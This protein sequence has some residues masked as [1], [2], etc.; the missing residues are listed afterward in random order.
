M[1]AAGIDDKSTA[2]ELAKLKLAGATNAQLNDHL[3]IKKQLLA[4]DQQGKAH[5]EQKRQ[6][7]QLK[8]EAESVRESLRSP[9]EGLAADF[10]K[11]GQFYRAGLL[12]AREYTRAKIEATK[13]LVQVPNN[14]TSKS[15][16]VRGAY[17]AIVEQQN[18]RRKAQLQASATRRL[19]NAANQVAQHERKR[20]K[21]NE[22]ITQHMK[23]QAVLADSIRGGSQPGGAVTSEG[24]GSS[25]VFE[26]IAE[27][28]EETARTISEWELES[29]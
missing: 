29:V 19:I 15:L 24:G 20:V 7:E 9:V 27:A 1:A 22:E 12:T 23:K 21:I 2:K 26:R 16:G 11:L 25:R 6:F 17:D 10:D 3:R 14:L 18:E 28:T 13:A 8:S 5:E 4:F